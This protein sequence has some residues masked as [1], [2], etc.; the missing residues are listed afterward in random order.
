MALEEIVDIVTS[1]VVGMDF[2]SDILLIAVSQIFAVQMYLLISISSERIFIGEDFP[3]RQSYLC[4]PLF[5]LYFT[6]LSS[7]CLPHTGS[8]SF[9]VMKTM[10]TLTSSAHAAVAR[11]GYLSLT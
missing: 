9:A 10:R 1:G 7:V 2:V 4:S 11:H 5:F 3:E 8:L 6:P